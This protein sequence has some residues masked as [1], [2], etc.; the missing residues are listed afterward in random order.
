MAV[1]WLHA[2]SPQ[3]LVM[4]GVTRSASVLDALAGIELEL[5]ADQLARIEAELPETRPMDAE[6]LGDLPAE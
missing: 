6:L 2:L 1:A 4:P 5:S 3:L